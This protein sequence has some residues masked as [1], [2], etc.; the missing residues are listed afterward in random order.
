MFPKAASDPVPLNHPL[1]PSR[2]TSLSP[3]WTPY[4]APSLVAPVVL[5]TGEGPCLVFDCWVCMIFISL[6]LFS[7]LLLKFY[8]DLHFK[9]TSWVLIILTINIL[10]ND[11]N[12]IIK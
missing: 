6:S 2:V 3:Q 8:S 10:T 11:L 1:H 7:V 4:K 5:I 12:S 9:T